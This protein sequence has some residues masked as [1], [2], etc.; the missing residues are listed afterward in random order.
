M[1]ANNDAGMSVIISTAAR[2]SHPPTA[3]RLKR[4]VTRSDKGFVAMWF[5]PSLVPV[6]EQGFQPGILR[7]GYDSVVMNRVEHVKRIDDEIIAQINSSRF[8][9]ANFTGHR[10]GVYFESGFALGVGLPVLW[11]CRKDDMKR[12]HFDIRQYN[13]IHWDNYEDLATRLQHRIEATVGKGPKA[14]DS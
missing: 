2:E 1:N 10:G 4:K 8:V 7:V 11:T 9:V 13:T 3:D 5:D 6:Y 14:V 12:L